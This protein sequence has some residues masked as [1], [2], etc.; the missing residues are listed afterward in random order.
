MVRCMF[1]ENE[2]TMRHRRTTREGAAHAREG[3]AHAQYGHVY[4]CLG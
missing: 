1:V 2:F 4:R 3:A